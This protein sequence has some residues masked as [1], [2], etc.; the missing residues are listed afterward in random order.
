MYEGVCMLVCVNVYMNMSVM[1]CMCVRWSSNV[2]VFVCDM[3]DG[4]CM[5]ECVN[6]CEVCVTVCGRV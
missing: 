3:C 5:C 4:V 1:K 6:V 2:S